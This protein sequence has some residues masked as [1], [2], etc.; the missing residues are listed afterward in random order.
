MLRCMRGLPLASLCAALAAAGLC[1][2]PAA[3]AALP[4]TEVHGPHCPPTGCAGAAGSIGSAL[5][6]FAVASLAI[7]VAG[8]RRTPAPGTE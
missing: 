2:A 7:V 8:R 3:S 1:V 4:E 6:G 5:A